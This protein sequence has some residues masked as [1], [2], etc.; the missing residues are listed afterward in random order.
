MSDKK[1][2]NIKRSKVNKNLS[3]K[4]KGKSANYT[5]KQR[6][7]AESRFRSDSLR[8]RGRK[9]HA[10]AVISQ[11]G[12]PAARFSR[13]S[14]LLLMCASRRTKF[15]GQHAEWNT[16]GAEYSSS[17]PR[18]FFFARARALLFRD[19]SSALPQKLAGILLTRVVPNSVRWML[20]IGFG[21]FRMLAARCEG[22]RNTVSSSTSDFFLCSETFVSSVK[23]CHIT[24]WW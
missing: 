20:M 16:A 11:T 14:S 21:D 1:Q 10:F 9:S 23:K 22:S 12:H 6:K 19:G 4:K 15:A 3:R 7:T 8:P 24:I 2:V 18:L 5:E 17:V 13:G